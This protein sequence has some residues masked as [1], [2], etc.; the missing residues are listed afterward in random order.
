MTN[1]DLQ[2]SSMILFSFSL[3]S[4]ASLFP[5]YRH[6]PTSCR[7]ACRSCQS[8][9]YTRAR[10]HSHLHTCIR[11]TKV[12]RCRTSG[13]SST[14]I[15]RLC[16]HACT[17]VCMHVCMYICMHAGVYARVRLYSIVPRY[18]LNG[19][20]LRRLQCREDVACVCVYTE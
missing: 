1:V 7:P 18:S 12:V 11:E 15:V 14:Y 9:A 2:A 6:F 16:T 17:C 10:S 8:V 13:Y 4:G 19:P 5:G 20:T 3:V